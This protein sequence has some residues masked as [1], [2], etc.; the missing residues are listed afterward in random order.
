MS[1]GFMAKKNPPLNEGDVVGVRGVVANSRVRPCLEVGDR[2]HHTPAE[3]S[4]SRT[5]SDYAVLLQRARRKLQEIG[6]FLV[7]EEDRGGL[8]R[9]RGHDMA[10]RRIEKSAVQLPRCAGSVRED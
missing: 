10:L 3:L 1:G 8:V 6:S 7:V 4:K 2:I 9:I 5:A